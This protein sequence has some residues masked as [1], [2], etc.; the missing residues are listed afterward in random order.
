M[1]FPSLNDIKTISDLPAVVVDKF[2]QWLTARPAAQRRYIL[3]EYFSDDNEEITYDIAREVMY[4]AVNVGVLQ[5][6]YEINC[7]VCRERVLTVQRQL[8]IPDHAHCDNC[9]TSFNPW[10]HMELIIISFRI[11]K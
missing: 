5:T 9:F 10:L 2:D 1:S 4:Y 8:D 3:P 11:V 7:P 6:N